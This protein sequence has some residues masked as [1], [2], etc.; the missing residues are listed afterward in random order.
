MRSSFGSA[1]GRL[2]NLLQKAQVGIIKHAD[3]RNAVPGECR[4][5]GSDSERPTGIS[6]GI[7][8]R[9]LEDLR[10]DHASA[11][12]LQPSCSLADGTSDAAADAALYV[13]LG[14]WLGEREE[15][16]T[17]ARP[18]GTE[19]AVREP[20]QRRLEIDEGNPLVHA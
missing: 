1:R 4:A 18:G 12:D 17:K 15:A 20:V 10:M 19:E 13:H 5:G 6:L 2:R 11:E 16:R 9:R 8:A 14:G 3:V 7:D